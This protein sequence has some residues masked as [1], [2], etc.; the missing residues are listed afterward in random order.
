MWLILA[1]VYVLVP[2]SCLVHSKAVLFSSTRHFLP[3]QHLPWL[4]ASSAF[5]PAGLMAH[6]LPV[7]HLT[8]SPPSDIGSYISV[9]WDFGYLF[10]ISNYPHLALNTTDVCYIIKFSFSFTLDLVCKLYGKDWGRVLPVLF[11]IPNP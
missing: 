4:F 5:S 11:S 1:V 6:V 3:H 2:S 7:I 9:L 8:L 10:Q